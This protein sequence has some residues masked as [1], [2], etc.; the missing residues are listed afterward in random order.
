MAEQSAQFTAEWLRLASHRDER[1]RTLAA[2]LLSEPLALRYFPHASHAGLHICRD[3]T[4][5][6]DATRL[7]WIFADTADGSYVTIDGR[8]TAEAGGNLDEA[9]RAEGNL[10]DAVIAFIELLREVG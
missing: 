5:P 6:R 7:P 9:V 3:A 8:L 1:V 4:D 2:R 10:E